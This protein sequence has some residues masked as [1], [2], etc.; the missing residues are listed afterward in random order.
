MLI[1][2]ILGIICTLVFMTVGIVVLITWGDEET[3]LEQRYK[4]K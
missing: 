1:G 2:F 3:Y 4:G